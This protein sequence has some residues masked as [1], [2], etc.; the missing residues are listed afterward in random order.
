MREASGPSDPP[1]Q[2][3]SNGLGDSRPA[4]FPALVHVLSVVSGSTWDI[5]YVLVL[6]GRPGLHIPELHLTKKGAEFFPL[7]GD[8]RLQTASLGFR[9]GPLR[10]RFHTSSGGAV[11][12]THSITRWD[13]A[14]SLAYRPRSLR[15]ALTIRR[16]R[17]LEQDRWSAQ[18]YPQIAHSTIPVRPLGRERGNAQHL[19]YLSFRRDRSSSRREDPEL[20][21]QASRVSH[22]S[23]TYRVRQV[24]LRKVHIS[25]WILINPHSSSSTSSSGSRPRLRPRPTPT[26]PHYCPTLLGLRERSLPRGVLRW[27]CLAAVALA[28]PVAAAVPA[29]AAEAAVALTAVAGAVVAA[30]AAAGQC[31]SRSVATISPDFFSVPPAVAAPPAYTG[32]V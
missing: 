25:N 16:P 6:A 18:P 17:I 29:V 5:S 11:S 1:R 23:S 19:P 28:E 14:S 20:L 26:A 30:V 8:H 21:A 22:T 12:E 2:P 27:G 32:R 4:A 24:P 10:G 7:R 15:G 9:D 13:S 3:E 31:A